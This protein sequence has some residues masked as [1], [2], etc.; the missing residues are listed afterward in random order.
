MSAGESIPEVMRRPSRL[1]ALA[2]LEA[3][4]E[5]SADALDRIARVA[6]RM[7]GVPVVLVNLVGGAAGSWAGRPT[8]RGPR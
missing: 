1:R 4:A 5:S 8:S 3:N 2:S 6:C 7:L